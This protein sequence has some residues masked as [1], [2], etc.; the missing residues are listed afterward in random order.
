MRIHLLAMIPSIALAGTPLHVA[1]LRT[2]ASMETLELP[3]RESLGLLGLSSTVDLGPFYIGPGLYGAAR[4]QRGGLFTFG[5]EGGGRWRPRPDSPLELEAGIFLGG[6]GGAG[7]PRQGGGLMVRPHLT[8][9]YGWRSLRVGAGLSRVRFPNGGIDSTQATFS[10]AL[11]TD[12]LWSSAGG[13][14]GSYAGP[15]AWVPSGF[16]LYLARLEPAAGAH[17]RSGAL[18]PALTLAGCALSRDLSAGWFRYVAVA[19][20]GGGSSS[21]YAQALV[22]LGHRVPLGGHFG[23]EA[24]VGAGIGGGG[25]LDTGGGFLVSAE[26]AFTL[27][28]G[29][30]RTSAGFGLL[31]SPAGA[32]EGRGLAFRVARRFSSPLPT[33]GGRPLL[34][35][36]LSQW[37]VSSGWLSYRWAQR[38]HGGPGVIQL[39]T[40]RADLALNEAWYLSGEAGSAVAGGSAAYSTGLAGVGRQSRAWHHLRFFLEG[41]V[42][43]GGGGS[44]STGGGLLA[45]IRAGGRLELP[46]GLGL[47]ASIG[48]VRAPGGRL[49]CT[50]LGASLH[51][52]M[53]VPA[54]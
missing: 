34:D 47:D 10:V 13:R 14:T 27:D 21:G 48:R 23:L 5:L 49:D 3:G 31:R 20:A 9:S 19:G 41:A 35:A 2:T 37:R 7:A 40:L 53:G 24:R 11:V 54:R 16:A 1:P 30:W 51:W 52:R 22:G 33:E 46:S 29:S 32:F 8:A 50:T 26:G 42:G 15:A 6:G 44:L 45:S 36:D 18:Q 12:H 43:A 38:S 25:D 28:L 4:G 17:T 39:I